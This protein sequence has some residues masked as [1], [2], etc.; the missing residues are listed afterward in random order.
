MLKPSLGVVVQSPLPSPNNSHSVSGSIP[1]SSS[2]FRLEDYPGL[3]Y[4]LLSQLPWIRL[5]GS[6]TLQ[7]YSRIGNSFQSLPASEASLKSAN[8]HPKLALLPRTQKSSELRPE[9]LR[10]L[11]T[12]PFL[13][14]PQYNSHFDSP[15]K[16]DNAI[17]PEF[18]YFNVMKRI[19]GLISNNLEPDEA[20]EN[21][22]ELVIKHDQAR[23]AFGF[24]LK[25][26]Q[27]STIA[28]AEKIII[29]AICSGSIPLVRTLLDFGLDVTKHYLHH[30][31]LRTV[32]ILNGA[33]ETGDEKMVEW[34]LSRYPSDG[35][36]RCSNCPCAQRCECSLCWPLVRSAVETG[37]VTIMNMVLQRQPS[38]G[39]E[40]AI[41]RCVIAAA[42]KGQLEMV[43]CLIARYPWILEKARINPLPILE[44]TAIYTDGS[45]FDAMKEL[46][47][48]LF[49]GSNYR[50]GSVLT[51]AIL[52]PNEALVR[53][54]LTSLSNNEL[55]NETRNWRREFSPNYCN[56]FSDHDKLVFR[57]DNFAGMYALNAA[58][59]RRKEMLVKALL[60][61]GFDANLRDEFGVTPLQAAAWAGNAYVVEMLL[62]NN[63]DPDLI[64]IRIGNQLYF[65]KGGLRLR[66]GK[67]LTR[68]KKWLD[69]TLRPLEIALD[70][71]HWKAA[72]LIASHST[73]ASRL[74]QPGP[75]H[76]SPLYKAIHGK[77]LKHYPPRSPIFKD[78][79]PW[80]GIFSKAS[81]NDIAQ[82]QAK[83]VFT[84]TI[85]RTH[86]NISVMHHG[87]DSTALLF[88]DLLIEDR[89]ADPEFL[90]AAIYHGNHI[91]VRDAFELIR[92]KGH[93]L[94]AYTGYGPTELIIAVLQEDL[95]MVELLLASGFDPHQSHAMLSYIQPARGHFELLIFQMFCSLDT[96]FQVAVYMIVFTERTEIE[97]LLK[98]LQ[99]IMEWGK[100]K[101]DDD[102]G[103]QTP[104]L[105]AAYL[106]AKLRNC[107]A[108]ITVFAQQGIDDEIFRTELLGAIP[109]SHLDVALL[110][111]LDTGYEE[112]LFEW[113]IELGAGVNASKAHFFD[114]RHKWRSPLQLVAECGDYT[115]VKKLLHLGADVNAPA[116]RKLGATALQFAAIQG[117][118]EILDLLLDA[119]ADINAPRGHYEGRTAIEG[120][121]E[122][123]RLD[124]TSYLLAK[125]AHV[126]GKDS[127]TYRRAICRAYRGGHHAVTNLIQDWKRVH[128]GDDDCE[129]TEVIC[130]EMTEDEL[131]YEF[132]YEVNSA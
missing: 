37:N 106:F 117:N 3:E 92:L 126:A 10:Y 89:T 73:D 76:T 97:D 96:P 8:Q 4:L 71:G 26:R 44:A 93:S 24:L 50:G 70:R 27:P 105:A 111:H 83:G 118:F 82:L 9:K 81:M 65:P 23:M 116:G 129:A 112:S 68:A 13:P 6:V 33:V 122:W 114:S 47:I 95:R 38:T 119:G 120:A 79:I 30:N 64:P 131:K 108:L 88:P 54:L 11:P 21:V 36:Q 107:A 51:V 32:S 25:S 39:S 94:K 78:C 17:T 72:Q 60:D 124:M 53:K 86:L 74:A 100:R 28:L 75:C 48:E 90:D 55:S 19:F 16:S 103:V 7:E 5:A 42:S 46:G 130:S 43:Q 127:S 15:Y 49:P 102:Q 132:D 101:S 57:E 110:Y 98:I 34:V 84:H 85:L 91:F 20:M 1:E 56:S 61:R 66:K 125:G 104:H 2:L 58:I 59:G 62:E 113:L 87:V 77:L 41:T 45:M 31:Y 128:F 12:T 22:I 52:A 123:G 115:L 35:L 69:P 63:A 29:P 80:C 109:S 99:K 18:S 40:E 121:A 14:S 67:V